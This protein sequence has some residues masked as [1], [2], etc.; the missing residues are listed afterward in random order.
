M[1][2]PEPNAASVAL[3]REGRVLLIRRARSP[4]LGDWTL[5]GGRREPG[6]TIETTAI[7]EVYEEIGVDIRDIV[8][9][10]RMP[11]G[12]GGRYSLQVFATETFSG[13]IVLS[14]EVSDFAWLTRQEIAPRPITP[15]LMEV[16]DLAFSAIE[17]AHSAG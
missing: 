1:T 3:L 7:R 8:P 13:E 10:M 9:V 4:F 6:E 11:V 12:E 16:L 2:L 15:R 17:P 5:P 14:D